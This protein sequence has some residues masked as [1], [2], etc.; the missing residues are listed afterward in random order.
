MKNYKQLWI[1]VPFVIVIFGTGILNMLSKDKTESLTEN[2]ALQQRPGLENIIAKDYP[3]LY[4]SYYTDQ[5]IKRNQLL[6]LYTKFE[7]LTKKSNV[8]GYYINNQSWILPGPVAK[9]TNEQTKIYADKLNEFSKK[10]ASSGREVFYVSTPCKSQALNHLYSKY[11]DKGYV[12]ENLKNFNDNLDNI[13]FI[14]LDKYF[15]DEFSPSEKEKMYFKTDHHWNEI[16]AF[17]G[18]KYIVKNMN[19]LPKNQENLLDDDNFSR[20]ELKDRDFIGSYNRNLFYLFSKN[21]SVPYVKSNKNNDYKFFNYNGEEYVETEENVLIS[22]ERDSKEITYGGAYTNDIPLY[23]IVNKNAPIDKKLLIVRDSYQAPTTLLF[24]DLF[25]QV[26]I[27]DPRNTIDITV[28][29]IVNQGNPD[30]V[31]FM[32]NSETYGNMIDLI[33]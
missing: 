4:E 15:T 7:I 13:K 6:K 26:E 31:M 33:K 5:F 8:R 32:F 9:Q 19:I 21:E 17:E 25:K 10:I 22:T 1:T 2:R 16:G 18:F 3:N 14:G 11:A 12:L 28:S 29:K 23:K 20:Y 27:L 24:A 30:I